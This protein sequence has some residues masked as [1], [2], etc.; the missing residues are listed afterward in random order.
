MHPCDRLMHLQLPAFIGNKAA[1]E[2]DDAN[3]I[4]SHGG[5]SVVWSVVAARG[6]LCVHA[7]RISSE[8]ISRVASR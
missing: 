4:L 3:N 1:H 6:L 5:K 7:H 8:R 2:E